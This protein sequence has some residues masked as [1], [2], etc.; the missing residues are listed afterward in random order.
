[1]DNYTVAHNF[2]YS[3]YQESFDKR[4]MTVSYYKN[5]FYSYSTVIGLVV[6]T[7]DD[8]RCL[9]VSSNTM[10]A[11]TAKHI[12]ILRGACPY[13]TIIKV[14]FNYGDSFYYS[15]DDNIIKTLIERLYKELDYFKDSKLTQ[16]ANR[17]AYIAVFN[18]LQTIDEQIK[19]VDK[20][21]LNK[22]KKLYDVLINDESLKELKT[23]L[24]KQEQREKEK[25]QR[26]LNKLLKTHSYTSL[27]KMAYDSLT[28]PRVDR[29]VI[30]KAI[31]PENKLSFCWFTENDTVRTS[32]NITISEQEARIFLNRFKQG[33]VKH[34]DTISYYTVLSVTT[35]FITIGCHTIPIKN[36]QELIKELEQKELKAAA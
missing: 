22:Y 13:Y 34:G 32:K 2:F 29:Q 24:K 30:R 31:N 36:I 1:M 15:S 19:N 17:E 6:N 11:T 9:L 21:K 12:G 28:T 10:S 20:R 16:K 5:R 27:I 7:K 25:A 14:P 26:E 3:G 33:K 18:T 8:N 35:D 23:K 4:Y